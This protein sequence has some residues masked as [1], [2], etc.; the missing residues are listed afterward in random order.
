MTPNALREIAAMTSQR[1]SRDIL[2]MPAPD[3]DERVSYGSDPLQFGD[4]RLPPG[5]GPHPVAIIIHGGFW[6]AAFSL[7]H[8][9]HLAAALTETGVA[10]WTLEYRRIGDPGG[11]WPGTFLDVGAGVDF[12]RQL[13]ESRPLDLGRVATV[14]HSAG[15]HL[16][17]W[18]AGR[19]GLPD[20][21]PLATRDPFRPRGVVSLAG[22]ADLR[23]AWELELSNTVVA[24]L[25]GGSPADVPERYREASPIERP[26]LHLPQYLVHG[27]NDTTVP[28][29]ISE[30]YVE[31]ARQEG[32]DARLVP[33]EGAGHFELIDPR[34]D[35]WTSVAGAVGDL[36]HN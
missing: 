6:R 35:A 8:I 19:S 14:G 10:T 23:R 21:S 28:I 3:A 15:G 7:D 12:L 25:L 5:D 4:L 30:H 17:L 1:N 31:R 18:L 29:E 11:G 20:G 13:A 16:V 36:L 34:S 32:D 24:D 2:G 22:V 26:A 9:G 33:L 27:T